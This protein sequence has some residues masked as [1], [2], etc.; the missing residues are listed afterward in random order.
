MSL[1]SRIDR[2]EIL[3]NELIIESQKQSSFREKMLD[4][5]RIQTQ[6][7]GKVDYRLD[8]LEHRMEKVEV[9]MEKLEH[10]VEKVEKD[11]KEVKGDVQIIKDYVIKP[12][13]NGHP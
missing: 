1:E 2:L 9:K 13:K 6:W 4:Y 7:S 10:R 5:A 11:L 12:P 3:M 8:K